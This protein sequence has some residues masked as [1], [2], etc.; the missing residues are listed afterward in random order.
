MHL[1][2]AAQV[3]SVQECR[4]VSTKVWPCMRNATVGSIP[5]TVLLACARHALAVKRFP[6]THLPHIGACAWM[7]ACSLSRQLSVAACF[8]YARAHSHANSPSQRASLRRCGVV[9]VAGGYPWSC[10]GMDDTKTW[11]MKPTVMEA[12]HIKNP[13][14]SRFSYH[15]S[16]PVSSSKRTVAR[17]S[18]RQIR[19]LDLETM[20]TWHRIV[21]DF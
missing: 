13:G 18:T 1:P 15:S 8:R 12:L 4:R 6:I 21:R 20:V 11:M 10:G 19:T 3:L 16:G 7:C 14:Q 2:V 5:F 17:T 9:Y